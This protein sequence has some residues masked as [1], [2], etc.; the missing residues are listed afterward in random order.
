MSPHRDPS[1]PR[2][3]PPLPTAALA[4]CCFAAGAVAWAVAG[5]HENAVFLAACLAVAALAALA[6]AL[7]T[8]RRGPGPTPDEERLKLALEGAEDGIWDW[9][10]ETDEMAFNERWAAMLGYPAGEVE[11]SWEEWIDLVHPDDAAGVKKALEAHLDGKIPVY[12]AEHRI[13]D[14]AGRWRWIQARG[15]VVQRGELGVP[16][17][18][19]GTHKDITERKRAREALL[20]SEALI[21][22]ILETAPDGVVTFSSH[23]RIESFNAAAEHIFGWSAAE[24][25]GQDLSRLIPDAEGSEGLRQ[26]LAE[27]ARLAGRTQELLGRRRDGTTFPMELSVGEVRLRGHRL[28]TGLLRDIT[29]RK[30]AEEDLKLFRAM[31]ENMSEGVQLAR[32]RDEVIVYANPAL[33]QMCAYQPGEL[34]GQHV[35]R[36]YAADETGTGEFLR[37][38]S[39]HLARQGFW[40]GEV[41]ARKKS[42]A[43]FWC[44]IRIST[45]DHP[46]FGRVWVSVHEDI[47]TRV[48]AEE[49]RY[50]LEDQL[51][52]AH[53]MESIG[54]LAG[55]VAHEF[56]NLLVGIGGH[57]GFAL[58][59]VGDQPQLKEDLEEAQ[60]AAD[61]AA[62]L[63]HKLLAF[64]RRQVLK[65]S[66]TDLNKLVEE[67]AAMLRTAV[68]ENIELVLDP[69]TDLGRV[70]VDASQ[71]EQVVLNL[72]INARDAMPNGGALAIHTENV[73]LD[74]AFCREHPWAR[75]GSY[76]L[77]SL[78]DTGRGMDEAMLDRIFEPFFTT[79]KSGEGTGLGLAMVH[80][81]VRQHD[82][83]L[84]VAS[85][86]GEGTTVR[87]FWPRLDGLAEGRPEK[88]AGKTRKDTS[89]TVI[90]AEDDDVV[91]NVARRIL[92]D[93][94][95]TVLPAGNGEEAVRVFAERRGAV[96]LVILDLIMPVMGG[97][98]CRGKIL[99]IRP[100][101]RIL[102]A[103]GYSAAA[104]HQGPGGVEIPLIAKP[105]DRR[106]LLGKVRDVLAGGE[107]AVRVYTG[108]EGRSPRTVR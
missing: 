72:C 43:I 92:E 29:L 51:R 78:S 28:F 66:D 45:F 38:V 74:K 20:R 103:S 2:A 90:L 95:Y 88:E 55:G 13:R 15:K 54:Q 44:G 81:V 58:E 79:K 19:S 16:L 98:A 107:T 91:R 105:F 21:R 106:T 3:F 59:A 7:V 1:P 71:V 56:N 77:L 70:H 61:R 87:I 10:L 8:R 17:R 23:G 22:T 80:G 41:R 102:L 35:S 64:S 14:R 96:D 6:T 69:G 85:R 94:G 27:S 108:G 83:L 24:V 62:A 39:D 63:T 12:Q 11:L 75:P 37:E 101:A 40:R 33:E 100:D 25:L 34:M 42:G 36:I 97:L 50:W 99:E 46:R 82:A 76:V 89:G 31:V 32:I 57:L 52:Q 60:A 73:D 5:G 26:R 4:L 18:A 65:R 104:I 53:R 93:A 48:R 47:T 84:D 49:E 9:N 68:T 67:L 30:E 86:P